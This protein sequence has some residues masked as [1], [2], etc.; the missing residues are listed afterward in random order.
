MP[1]T[2]SIL[3]SW[4][5]SIWNQ[6]L[7]LI[8]FWTFANLMF[9]LMGDVL[10]KETTTNLAFVKGREAFNK[11]QAFRLWATIHGGI[12]VPATRETPPNPYLSHLPERDISTQ[13]G[14]Y[15]T[16]MNPAYMIRQLNE[17]YS[18]LFGIVGHITSLN[19][20]RPG[21]KADPWEQHALFEFEK[22]KNE[23]GEIIKE[24]GT[25]YLRLMKPMLT[26]EG[27]LKCH[28]HQGYKI[29]D[30]RGGVSVK[31]PLTDILI[32][33]ASQ[34]MMIYTGI[35]AIWALGVGFLALGGRSLRRSQKAREQA[36]KE[37]VHESILNDA[38]AQIVRVFFQ[39]SANI[40]DI[41][42]KVYHKSL[43]ISNSSKGYVS[44][45]DPTSQANIIH[46]G[47]NMADDVAAPISPD[48]PIILSKEPN[49]YEGLWGHS[50][51]TRKAFYTNSPKTHP[52]ATG[53]PDEHLPL[54]NFMSIP[55]I[56]GDKIFGQISL[57]NAD[58]EYTDE[59]LKDVQ[60]LADIFAIG[61]HRHILQK[62]LLSAKNEAEAA[63]KAKS[64]FLANMSHEVRTPL[65]GIHG[66][67]Q[68][69]LDTS[70][71]E[72]QSEY[73]INATNASQRLS[74]LLSDILD[75]SRVE[76]G[77][78]L[79]R[80]SPINLENILNN[81]KELFYPTL[82]QS[83]LTI[84]HSISS[85]LPHQLLGDE[86]RILQVLVNLVGNAL[87]FTKSGGVSITLSPLTTTD[88]DKCKILFIIADTGV[89]I[90]DDKLSTLFQPFSQVSKGYRRD[91]QGAGLGLVIT[92]RLVTLM[93]GNIAV[94]SV[95][96]KGTTIYFT[97]FL[98]I[99]KTDE[100][101]HPL[102]QPGSVVIQD[103]QT[104]KDLRIL[105]AED[106]YINSL[107]ASRLLAKNGADV[108]VVENGN[109]ALKA[110]RQSSFDLVLM[111][112]QMPIMD[113]VEA[114]KAIRKG[115]AG[116]T[117]RAIPIIALTAYAMTG[118]V[119]TFLAAGMNAYQAKPVN[120]ETLYK[121]ITD[122]V[123]ATN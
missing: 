21:N 77:K 89:G 118:D 93:G 122:I 11:D 85:S 94:E 68:I 113:G 72:E 64:E 84:R 121:A 46:T 1:I 76:A 4:R 73:V 15:L 117:N 71:T 10:L 35:P 28:A 30:I 92:K 49:G 47:S 2:K 101:V 14:K 95:A 123:Q 97:C 52:A 31:V 87:K 43:I 79:I 99:S 45:I 16:L 13:S 91:H 23:I 110:L 62:K 104:L 8:V 70:L 109:E 55:V 36:Q 25:S 90:P 103:A 88:P 27:C 120:I 50:L 59:I 24:N 60:S 7:V 80:N 9:G 40:N 112:I 114:T 22:G 74:H 39:D 58:Q 61:L 100:T 86:T 111:D 65:N 63:N 54:Y 98:D 20:L 108:V 42:Q 57:A 18:Q 116:N 3:R 48:T 5:K 32:F 83:G 44:S 38:K 37:T 67:L 33:T 34:R 17:H 6:A 41:A 66:M 51:N 106:E 78:M 82:K 56:Y 19:P 119:D 69:L 102:K 29:G 75:L 81:I 105:M 96:G 107:A 53:L 12:Y 115:R 26:E